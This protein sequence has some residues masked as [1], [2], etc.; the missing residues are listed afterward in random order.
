LAQR[1]PT[2]IDTPIWYDD[3]FYWTFFVGEELREIWSGLA[4][5][6]KAAVYVTAKA[7]S[8]YLHDSGVFDD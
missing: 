3:P 6:V 4:P 8:E 2:E 7:G 1:L 5:L